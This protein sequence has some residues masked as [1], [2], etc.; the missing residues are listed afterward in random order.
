[1]KSAHIPNLITCFRLLLVVPTL[2]FLVG[3]HYRGAFTLFVLAGCSDGLDGFLARRFGWTS[4]F[5]AIVDPLADKLLVVSTY[6]TLTLINAL[7]TWVTLIV[8]G[9]DLLIVG[10]AIVCHAL[11]GRYEIAPS[12]I[13]KANTFCQILLIFFVLLHLSFTSI[14]L[15]IPQS[16]T[17]LVLLTTI[18]SFIDYGKIWGARVWQVVR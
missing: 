5:G 15:W 9:R 1:M 8:V 3:E 16:L 6:I 10:G 14:P 4:R 7:P 12:R 2:F 18:A 11:L 17:Y 13:S